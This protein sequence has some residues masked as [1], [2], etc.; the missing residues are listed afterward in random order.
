MLCKLCFIFV[1]GSDLP[2]WSEPL[3]PAAFSVFVWFCRAHYYR[4]QEG[5]GG[6]DS[7]WTSVYLCSPRRPPGKTRSRCASRLGEAEEQELQ[8][9]REKTCWSCG[10]FFPD[11][12]LAQLS[13]F[14]CERYIIAKYFGVFAKSQN[15]FFLFCLCCHSDDRMLY[16]AWSLSLENG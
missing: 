1:S 13:P 10:S 11:L 12:L 9:S 4:G 16:D 2:S 6:W 7:L 14:L 5:W 3:P 15:L 8:S